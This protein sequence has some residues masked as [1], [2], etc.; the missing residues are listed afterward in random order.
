MAI[1]LSVAPDTS[2]AMASTDP[3]IGDAGSSDVAR[4]NDAA[5]P[6]PSPFI[7][8]NSPSHWWARELFG[9]SLIAC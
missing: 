8:R 3:M 1:P 9:S 6:G 2:F 4:F 7:S 5:A